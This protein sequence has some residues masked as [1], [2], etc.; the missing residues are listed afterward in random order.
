MDR[1]TVIPSRV[2]IR[3]DGKS[4]SMY[5]S[6]PWG[7]PEEK[8]RWALVEQGWTWRDN[9]SNTIGLGRVPAK[10]E[11]EAQAIADYFNAK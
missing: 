10:T 1:I 3:D 7:S 2:Y 8:K 11:A 5:G 9:R 4:A 6:S